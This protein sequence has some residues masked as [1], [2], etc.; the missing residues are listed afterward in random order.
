[1]EPA[2]IL[3]VD[4]EEELVST[5]TQRLALR[6]FQ[7]EG[8]TSAAEALRRVGEHDFSVMVLD[9]KMPGLDGL[10]LLA[11][12]KQEYPDLPVILFTGH[13]SVRDAERGMQ[14]GAFDYLVKPIDIDQLVEKIRNAAG[15][16]KGPEA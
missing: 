4:D 1:M 3:I 11:Q 16:K 13:T 10:E 9:V 5:L 12:I 6:G 15:R 2:R 8:A 14:V 7:A